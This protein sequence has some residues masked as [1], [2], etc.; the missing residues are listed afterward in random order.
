M[1]E[2]PKVS[3]LRVEIRIPMCS[4]AGAE[5]CCRE[6]GNRC[7]KGR[8]EWVLCDLKSLIS[9]FPQ[10]CNKVKVTISQR[11]QE[12]QIYKGKMRKFYTNVVH[13]YHPDCISI[14]AKPERESRAYSNLKYGIVNR[15]Y[16][17]TLHHFYTFKHPKFW[18]VTL[19]H[20]SIPK[21]K[22][23]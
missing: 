8:P 9:Q 22:N 18:E 6:E 3:G 4:F 12:N 5:G 10:L 19:A 1:D 16:S 17:W 13:Y 23:D 21:K 14:I 2:W 20:L 15:S 7:V 11:W